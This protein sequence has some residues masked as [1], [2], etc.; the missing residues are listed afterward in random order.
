MSVNH[1]RLC[2]VQS[3]WSV[4]TQTENAT[5]VA[6]RSARLTLTDKVVGG[7]GCQVYS[8]IEVAAGVRTSKQSAAGCSQPRQQHGAASDRGL[9]QIIQ[10]VHRTAANIRDY[11]TKLLPFTWSVL[12]D[13]ARRRGVCKRR[14]MRSAVRENK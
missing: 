2:F 1:C 8:G 9:L 7:D 3:T 5:V 6:R 10:H 12:Y 13:E 4:L 11:L 14:T